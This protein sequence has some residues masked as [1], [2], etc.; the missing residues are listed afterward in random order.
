MATSPLK[1][2]TDA[3]IAVGRRTQ[4]RARVMLSGI[5]EAIDGLRRVT[6]HNLSTGGALIETA[7][8]P[9]VGKEVVLKCFGIDAFGVV[10]W[11]DGDRCGIE[12]YDPI[13]EAEVIRQ[14]QL[15]EDEFA[16]LKWRTRK[17]MLEAAERW[18]NGKNA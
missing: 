12:F 14:R 4:A 7:R 11:E 17:D 10:V 3:A 2:S 5:I 6:V 18:S 9:S 8:A 1:Y 13:D 15:S 16:Q